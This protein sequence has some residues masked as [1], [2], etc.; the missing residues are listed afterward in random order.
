MSI[1]RKAYRDHDYIH[2]SID[3]LVAGAAWKAGHFASRASLGSVLPPDTVSPAALESIA[4][5]VLL[6]GRGYAA[7]QVNP[8]APSFAPL[9]D[10][11]K[12]PPGA[13]L[14]EFIRRVSSFEEP[15]QPILSR[16]YT[17][18]ELYEKA[19]E[20]VRYNSAAL[21]ILAYA[22]APLVSALSVQPYLLDQPQVPPTPIQALIVA[23]FNYQAEV[24]VLRHNLGYALDQL[25]DKV[26]DASGITDAYWAWHSEWTPE[27]MCRY[28]PVYQVLRRKGIDLSPV[29]DS[30]LGGLAKLRDAGLISNARFQACAATYAD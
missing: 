24:R 3:I 27:G 26:A 6:D 20:Q 10:P 29:R 9:Q 5:D 4:R 2:R 30:E 25:A 14:V 13:V 17:S 23:A 21:D 16:V 12:L 11:S 19:L 22:M 18:L 28:G 7:A 8:K 15:G 1:D